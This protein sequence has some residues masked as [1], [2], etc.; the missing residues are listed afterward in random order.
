MPP[1][2]G[3][4]N[5]LLGMQF[6]KTV[7]GVC[8]VVLVVFLVVLVVA[9]FVV[10]VACN[11][12]HHKSHHQDHQNRLR[13]PYSGTVFRKQPTLR[14]SPREGAEKERSRFLADRKLVRDLA[15]G[16]PGCS[17]GRARAVVGL[18]DNLPELTLKLGLLRVDS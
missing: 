7:G 18:R 14:D 3:S 10:V 2:L 16:T 15:R 1:P 12:H 17:S 5:G 8:L 4:T 11:Y 9:F 13:Q 6:R